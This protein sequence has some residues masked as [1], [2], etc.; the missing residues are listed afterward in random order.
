M[1][2]P[3]ASPELNPTEQ[4]WQDL[5]EE[6]LSNRSFD[7]YEDI[8]QSCGQAWNAFTMYPVES[9]IYA[10]DHGLIYKFIFRK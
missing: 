7:G 1:P 8:L 4:V 10:Q 5:R 2:L 9:N 6:W 3:T